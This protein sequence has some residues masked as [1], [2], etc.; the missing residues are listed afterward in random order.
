MHQRSGKIDHKKMHIK[1]DR[2][3]LFKY[4]SYL[5]EIYDIVKENFRIGSTHNDFEKYKKID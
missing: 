2:I 4:N 3:S 5:S 1:D